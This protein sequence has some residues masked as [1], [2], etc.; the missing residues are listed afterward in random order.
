M[1]DQVMIV[2]AGVVG[3][4][5]ARNFALEGYD[6]LIVER[7]PH[8][9]SEVSARNS[10]VIHAGIY[11]PQHS[12]KALACV[13]GRELLYE[14]CH[15]AGVPFKNLGKLIVATN[16]DEDKILKKIQA[17]ASL[18]GVELQLLSGA[19][20]CEREPELSATSALLS[21]RTGIVDCHELMYAYLADAEK[22]GAQLS[23]NTKIA[24]FK[25]CDNHVIVEGVSAGE[26]F[27]FEADLVV[28]AGGLGSYA[29]ARDHWHD[30]PAPPEKYAKGNYFS[31]SGKSPF[32]MLI[33]PVPVP[34][35]LGI[36]Y[37]SDLAGRGRLGPNVRW[38]DEL[39]Y[40]VE[41]ED[42]QVFRDAVRSYWPG[43]DDRTLQPDYAGI[44]PK[45]SGNDFVF[46]RHGPVIDLLGIESPGLTSSLA[47]A[48]MVVELAKN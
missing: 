11:Y 43:V 38:V 35:G 9:G 13:R 12:K 2:G 18:N 40:D 15:E 28:N 23:L 21:P 10:G 47:V 37:T 46:K 14:Y 4:A 30:A 27:V 31:I 42:E 36:H 7:H 39:S 34:G 48:Q 44:R 20:A 22:A 19:E 25:P 6:V 33:Y 5:C 29:L 32:D 41:I 16:E 17:N 3:L 24:R 1:S 8:I 26:E 45:I